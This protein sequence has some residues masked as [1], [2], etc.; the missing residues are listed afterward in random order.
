M[1]RSFALKLCANNVS[2]LWN[3]QQARDTI[4][5][6]YEIHFDLDTYNYRSG[7]LLEELRQQTEKF[8]CSGGIWTQTT[9]TEGEVNGLL[10][11]DRRLLR[12][13]EAQWKRQITALYSTAKKRG[14]A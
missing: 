12:P 2:S 4:N 6:T 11:Y 13:D 7:L 5:Q 10:T 8:A 14:G 9:D 3:V 1:N